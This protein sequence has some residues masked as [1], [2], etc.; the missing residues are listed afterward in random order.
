MG[1]KG[2]T[3][4][5]RDR[6]ERNAGLS[7]HAVD[8]EIISAMRIFTEFPVDYRRKNSHGGEKSD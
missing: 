8:D 3:K 1:D 4:R 5:E 7:V 6:S 2:K